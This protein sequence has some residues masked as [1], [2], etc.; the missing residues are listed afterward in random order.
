MAEAG[1]GFSGTWPVDRFERLATLLESP[2]DGEITFSV[3]FDCDDLRLPFA[4]VQASGQVP[5]R[6]QRTLERFLLPLAVK[7]RLGL[8]R[9]D[10]EAASL[11]DD[12]EPL[13]VV[14]GAVALMSIVEDE[15][16]LALPLVPVSTEDVV[17][18]TF[19]PAADAV[20]DGE[21]PNPFAVL[22]QLKKN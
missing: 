9:E 17:E 6:C 8:I 7:S 12:R 19:G 20:G 22:E 5:L 1:R 18:E 14:E 3:Q 16:I 4:D 15:V 10:G 2:V 21:A 11:P 13:V